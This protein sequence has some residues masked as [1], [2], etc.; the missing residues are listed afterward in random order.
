M[1][2]LVGSLLLQVTFPYHLRRGTSRSSERAT[3]SVTVRRIELFAIALLAVSAPVNATVLPWIAVRLVGVDLTATKTWFALSTLN[4]AA[5]LSLFRAIQIDCA[6]RRL[7]PPLAGLVVVSAGLAAASALSRG[8]VTRYLL[9]ALLAYG[10]GN[11]VVRF[12]GR[13]GPRQASPGARSR[14]SSSSE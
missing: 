1:L 5:L 6:E 14:A 11:V 12:W 7:R 3:G 8:D 10:L 2:Y 13:R 9:L 4:F